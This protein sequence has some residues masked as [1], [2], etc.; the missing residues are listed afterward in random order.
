[1][2]TQRF[3]WRCGSSCHHCLFPAGCYFSR[4][5]LTTGNCPVWHHLKPIRRRQQECKI[6]GLQLLYPQSVGTQLE[7]NYMYLREVN[8]NLRLASRASLQWL[9]LLFFLSHLSNAGWPESVCIWLFSRFVS[10]PLPLRAT[11]ARNEVPPP[12]VQSYHNICYWLE[13]CT[14]NQ[15]RRLKKNW[16]R[17]SHSTADV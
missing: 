9:L 11:A 15:S 1:M 13:G 16:K 7:L 10:V 2:Q 14:A 6:N 4:W 8:K 12:T 17:W 3:Q 5:F